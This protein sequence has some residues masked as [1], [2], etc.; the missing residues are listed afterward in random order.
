MQQPTATT[1]EKMDRKA[2]EVKKGGKKESRVSRC[3][4]TK[5][6]TQHTQQQT[7]ISPLLMFGCQTSHSDAA[8]LASSSIVLQLPACKKGGWKKNQR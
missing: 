8:S 3:N 2:N 4:L 7:Y 6:N 5:K 1:K